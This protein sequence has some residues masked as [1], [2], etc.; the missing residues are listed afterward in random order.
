[1]VDVVEAADLT[2]APPARQ[3]VYVARPPGE[4][5][6]GVGAPVCVVRIMRYCAWC[7]LFIKVIKVSL[8]VELLLRCQ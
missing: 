6:Q 1:M 2:A 8:G 3:A 7:H 4:L 5:N